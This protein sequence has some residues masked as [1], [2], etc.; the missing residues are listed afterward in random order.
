M[1]SLMSQNVDENEEYEAENNR[2][3]N[4]LHQQESKFS[5]VDET[6][7]T[8]NQ[9]GRTSQLNKLDSTNNSL[10]PNQHRQQHQRHSLTTN[11][12]SAASSQTKTDQVDESISTA[13][14]LSRKDPPNSGKT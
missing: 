12:L 9:T 4:H 3:D 10:S 8:T 5:S 1:K 13:R 2:V 14:R 7:T 11:L 6:T